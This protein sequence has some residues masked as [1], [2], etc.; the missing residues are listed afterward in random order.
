MGPS[1][2]VFYYKKIAVRDENTNRLSYYSTKPADLNSVK[3]TSSFVCLGRGEESSIP[4]FG[5]ILSL[6]SHTFTET[7]F[8]ALL[9]VFTQTNFDTDCNM[10]HVPV[11]S[12]VQKTV[13]MIR[14]Q[15]LSSPLVAAYDEDEQ[16]L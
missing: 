16:Q 10:W 4:K 13:V 15:C 5:C 8:W 14:S 12:P 9:E 1:N 11:N 6:F 7:T 3:M 2:E